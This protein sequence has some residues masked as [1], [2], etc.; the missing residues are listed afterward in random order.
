MAAPRGIDRLVLAPQSPGYCL[1]EVAAT[2]ERFNNMWPL[3]V[4]ARHHSA[5]PAFSSGRIAAFVEGRD[6][7]N[8]PREG[9]DQKRSSIEGNSEGAVCHSPLL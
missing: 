5:R 9:K 4:F 2:F 1:R 3:R 6:F 8:F 7:E